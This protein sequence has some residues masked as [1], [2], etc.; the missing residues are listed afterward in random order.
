MAG[1]ML[2]TKQIQQNNPAQSRNI[3][4]RKCTRVVSLRVLVKWKYSLMKINHGSF[5]NKS[6][7]TLVFSLLITFGLLITFLFFYFLSKTICIRVSTGPV[8]CINIL[9]THLFT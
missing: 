8:K 1:S 5:H 2:L 6:V 9:K 3:C 7:V 4:Q